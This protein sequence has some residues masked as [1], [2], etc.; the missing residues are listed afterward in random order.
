MLYAEVEPFGMDEGDFRAISL[1]SL[2]AS[3]VGAKIPPESFTLRNFVNQIHAPATEVGSDEA[4]LDR[5]FCVRRD[6]V[7]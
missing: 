1:N 2:I 6:Q 3:I 7:N 5:L 4:L